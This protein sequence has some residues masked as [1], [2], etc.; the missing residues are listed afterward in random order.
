[1]KKQYEPYRYLDNAKQILKEKAG[2]ELSGR[3]YKDPKY[4]RM[5][6]DTAYKGVILALQDW[7]KYKLNKEI[8]KRGKGKRGESIDFYRDLLKNRNKKM[9]KV[10]N[11]VYDS[12]HLHAGYDGSLLVAEIKEGLKFAKDLIDWVYA[13]VKDKPE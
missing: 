6:G 12:L 2:L 8:P 5:A 7:A 3:L 10:L 9:L 1:M 11:A 13:Q 4:V